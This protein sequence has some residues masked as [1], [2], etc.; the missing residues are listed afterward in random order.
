[1]S[2]Y[3]MQTGKT[4]V[5]VPVDHFRK[6]FS[7]VSNDNEGFPD[8]FHGLHF[9][10]AYEILKT[11]WCVGDEP[12][13]SFGTAELIMPEE[14]WGWINQYLDSSEDLK[15]NDIWELERQLQRRIA[16]SLAPIGPI[17][18][19]E[20]L[21]YWRVLF[22]RTINVEAELENGQLDGFCLADFEKAVSVVLIERELLAELT[23]PFE[24]AMRVGVT[25]RQLTELQAN[26]IASLLVE[27]PLLKAAFEG[28]VRST[29]THDH[30]ALKR[31][32]QLFIKLRQM[33]ED[34]DF[35]RSHD[36]V[37][38]LHM[39]ICDQQR[40]NDAG[41]VQEV[42]DLADQLR[43][44]LPA[45]A[46]RPAV[47]SFVCNLRTVDSVD[48]ST[49][50]ISGAT[51]Q[52]S[53]GFDIESTDEDCHSLSDSLAAP[54]E[55]VGGL[56]NDAVNVF[57]IDTTASSSTLPPSAPPKWRPNSEWLLSKDLAKF[58]G[59][60]P[61]RFNDYRK[62]AKLIG[63][64]EIGEWGRD[65]IGVFRRKACGNEAAYYLP[66]LNDLYQAKFELA[67]LRGVPKGAT[68]P[69]PHKFTE[70]PSPA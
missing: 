38:S 66:L 12:G 56:P 24:E 32:A 48:D 65:L 31:T 6:F 13:M 54:A 61:M 14:A 63:E 60:T 26:W 15:R 51:P 30:L 8:A 21:N 4:E 33:S 29:L 35:F 37:N 55:I 43:A 19:T 34:Y 16:Y 70:T 44:R 10:E 25:L 9:G 36:F 49:A 46:M 18:L 41:F 40:L 58:V 64:D 17:E 62:K 20:R 27:F 53:V 47:T 11:S 1:M 52:V 67:K 69:V 22:H 3:K 5:I 42:S 7:W 59:M 68:I 45:T 28:A 57:A 2:V 50:L 23:V 39:L